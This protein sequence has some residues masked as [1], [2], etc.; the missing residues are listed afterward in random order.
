MWTERA[1]RQT[2]EPGKQRKGGCFLHDWPL[3]GCLPCLEEQRVNNYAERRQEKKRQNGLGGSG[4][5]A[6]ALLMLGCF[7]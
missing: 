2:S 7:C 5:A 1:C 4:V 3:A 6:A